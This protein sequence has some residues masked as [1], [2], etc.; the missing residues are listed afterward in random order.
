MTGERRKARELALQALFEIDLAGHASNEVM[1]RAIETGNLSPEGAAF[2]RELLEG[3]VQNREKIDEQIRH[4]A[5]AWPL[6]QMA[7]VDRNILRL[8]I[9]ELLHNNKVPVKVAINEAV[10]LA[11]SFG[12]DSSP[13]FINGVLSSISHLATR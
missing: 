7:T 1:S 13:R 11:K 9:Y 12:A 3:V 6:D 2:A 4:F 8:A 10:E 5:P